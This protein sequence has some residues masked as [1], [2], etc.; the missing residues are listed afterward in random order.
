[1]GFSSGVILKGVSGLF[2]YLSRI[3]YLGYLGFLLDYGTLRLGVGG[4]MDFFS[5]RLRE[6]FFVGEVFFVG[7]KGFGLFGDSSVVFCEN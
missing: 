5:I 6:G 2:P 1:M 7:S 4:M 3:R